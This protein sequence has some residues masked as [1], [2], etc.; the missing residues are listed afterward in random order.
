MAVIKPTTIKKYFTKSKYNRPGDKRSRTTKI[1]WHYTGKAGVSALSTWNYFEGLKVGQYYIVNGVKK[2]I[3]AS[4]HF[5]VGLDGEIYE[6]MPLN[7]IGYTTNEANA[8]SIG[9][10]CATT[11]SDDHYTDKQYKA[12]VHLGAW[13]A[14]EYKLNPIE[15]AIR[16]KDVTGKVCPRYFVNNID[17]WKQFKTDQYNLLKG[18]ITL[19]DIKNCTNGKGEVTQVKA[20]VV[21]YTNKRVVNVSSEDLNIRDTADWNAKPSGVIKKGGNAEVVSK[22]SAKNGT[23]EMYK[24][25]NGKY[26][27]TSDKYVKL[28]DIPKPAPAP[29]PA[30]KKYIYNISGGSINIR[31]TAD[32][33][34]KVIGQMKKDEV[35]TLDKIVDAKNGNTK[36]YKTISGTYVTASSTFTKIVEK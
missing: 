24:L 16:H 23:T 29:A 22:V 3:Y 5:I 18:K 1:A 26:V 34:G 15:D 17:K 13:L 27:T 21:N 14:Q 11:G 9:I 10:E 33:N 7:E 31:S 32:W 30:K 4:S 19:A 25:K 20:P 8:Y 6:C 12:M 28:E 35:Y 2:Y 36:M